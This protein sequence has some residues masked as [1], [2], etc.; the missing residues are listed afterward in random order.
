MTYNDE[1]M[2]KLYSDKRKNP[3]KTVRNP[4]KLLKRS[5]NG[6]KQ[7]LPSQKTSKDGKY[8]FVPYLKPKSADDTRTQ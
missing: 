3:R 2:H 1:P 6:F 7:I 4:S 5:Q 8:I